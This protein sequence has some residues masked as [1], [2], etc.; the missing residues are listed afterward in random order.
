MTGRVPDGDAVRRR[1]LALLLAASGLVA[2]FYSV[3]HLGQGRGDRALA[4]LSALAMAA[5]VLGILGYSRSVRP[6]VICATLYAAAMT[7]GMLAT[8]A[9]APA[10]FIWCL[11][12]PLLVAYAG[13][14]TL[15][16]WVLPVY[17]AAAAAIVFFPGFSG[18]ALWLDLE[19]PVR[20]FGLLVLIS[21]VAY[22]YERTRSRAEARLQ[23]EIAERRTAEAELEDANRRLAETAE[24]AARLAVQ[25]QSANEAKTRFLSHMSHDIRTPLTGVMGMADLLD[26]TRLDATQRRYVETIRVG[27]DTLAELIGDVLDLARIEAGH[28]ELQLEAVDL[29][30]HVEEVYRVL[31]PLAHGKDLNLSA[32]VDE[33]LPERLMADPARLRQILL[34]LAGNAVKFTHQGAVSIVLEPSPG[35]DRGWW[36]LRVRDTGIGVP[37]D[38]HR[39]IFDSFSQVDLAGARQHGGSG[40]GLAICSR[41]VALMGG[42]MALR[43]EPG[44]G[45]EFWA[46]LPLVVPPVGEESRPAPP[47]PPTL[48]PLRLLV[49]DDSEIVRR[50]VVA[51]LTRAGHT[52]DEA[53]DGEAA[54]ARVSRSHYDAVL[55]DLQM[56]RMDG[57]EAIR[58]LRH[59]DSGALR[60]DVPVVA[61]TALADEQTRRRCLDA[62][63]CEVVTKPLGRDALIHALARAV[64]GDR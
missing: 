7:L 10:D 54:L 43:S 29:R 5:V 4:S 8:G 2:L 36:R 14:L 6:A 47:S 31:E 64:A 61:V 13:G 25:A 26:H 52:V 21:A 49:V 46:D 57:F 12:V 11:L 40:L 23:G 48:D 59:G 24:D 39:R 56:P 18:R 42:E 15:A 58:R 22:L 32:R 38:Q 33:E 41:L 35:R 3:Y 1:I 60:P 37:E 19:L 63:M 27:A 34:N 28:L 55:M 30:A 44:R 17:V 16:R 20:F 45:S 53:A 9:F 50:V 51:M 62:G